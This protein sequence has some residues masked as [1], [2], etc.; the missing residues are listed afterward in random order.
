MKRIFLFS[1]CLTISILSFGQQN[2]SQLSGRVRDA[3]TGEP[4]A[5]ASVAL[6]ES[7]QGTNTNE[8]GN[9]TLQ[10]IQGGHTVIEISYAGYRSIVEH[11]DISGNV[12]KDFSLTPSI[13]ENEGV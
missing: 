5:G 1:I 11:L 13:I 6:V 9:Y 7:K 12:Q 3:K 10:N 2:K 8:K 4:L